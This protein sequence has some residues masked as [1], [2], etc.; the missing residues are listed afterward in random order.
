MDI[1]HVGYATVHTPIRNLHLKNILHVPTAKKNL[2]S[3]HHFTTNNHAFM[4]FYLDFFFVRDQETKKTLLQAKCRGGPYPLPSAYVDSKKHAFGVNKPSLGRWHSR[5]G[6][7]SFSISQLV[8][9]KNNRPCSGEPVK[10]SICDV[11][12]KA[13]SHQFP[14]PKSTSVSSAPLELVYSLLC[15]DL[16]LIL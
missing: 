11:C 4:E 8:I 12:Q 7:P 5:L 9:N 6:H 16:L 10:Q 15:G 13:K 3:V 1:S 14:Y 2:L